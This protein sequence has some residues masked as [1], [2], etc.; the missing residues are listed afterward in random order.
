MIILYIRLVK[1]AKNISSMSFASYD[2]ERHTRKGSFYAQIDAIIDWKP[3]SKIIDK[4]YQKGL[5]AR[6]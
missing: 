1:R 2:V 5:S 4:H 3:I 6:Q